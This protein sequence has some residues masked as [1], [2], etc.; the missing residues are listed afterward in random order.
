MTARPAAEGINN[1]LGIRRDMNAL[2]S[3]IPP[4]VL[5]VLVAICM[6]SAA[7]LVPSLTVDF[8]GQGIL[9]N[10]LAVAG[11]LVSLAG[12]VAFRRAHTTVDPMRPDKASALVT[13]GIYRC[14]RHPMYLGFLLVLAA[15]ASH[16]SNLLSLVAL[17][18]FVAYMNRF[19]IDPEE[20]V[21]RAKFGGVYADYEK[22][23]RRWL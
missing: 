6:W 12:V 23:T 15:W 10:L 9:T 22:S 20:R 1:P 4:L 18:V 11:V 3:K 7:R 17:P 19:Q 21:L 8:T 13:S 2:E 16:L 14:S 5:V